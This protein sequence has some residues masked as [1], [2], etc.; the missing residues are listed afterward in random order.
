MASTVPRNAT[1]CPWPL[2]PE[3]GVDGRADIY[4]L[5]ILAYEA[6]TGDPPFVA[7]SDDEYYRCHLY[8]PVPEIFAPADPIL[9]RALAK[10]PHDRHRTV[11][12]LA[13][14]LQVAP[15]PARRGYA[16]RPWAGLWFRSYT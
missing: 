15:Q 8:E 9:Q 6:L 13:S 11:R 10:A 1:G 2:R 4:S 5:G 7:D 3:P 16:R 12:E 14:A